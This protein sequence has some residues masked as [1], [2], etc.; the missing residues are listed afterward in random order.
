MG[1]SRT[2]TITGGHTSLCCKCHEQIFCYIQSTILQREIRGGQRYEPLRRGTTWPK[3]KVQSFQER[4]GEVRGM[5]P[6]GGELLDPVSQQCIVTRIFIGKQYSLG[7]ERSCAHSASSRCLLVRLRGL[8]PQVKSPDVR[9][10]FWC[11]FLNCATAGT[12]MNNCLNQQNGL[13]GGSH[14]T[15]TGG[16]P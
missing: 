12:L 15:L 14:L 4:L 8:D 3:F 9:E 1:Y 10:T 13:G 7:Q 6:S 2:L 16:I 11:R 5:N